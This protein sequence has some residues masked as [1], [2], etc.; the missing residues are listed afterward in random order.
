MA[1]LLHYLP[2]VYITQPQF[3]P[4]PMSILKEDILQANQN[5]IKTANFLTK[6][7]NNPLR[8]KIIGRLLSEGAISVNGLCEKLKTEQSVMSQHLAILREAKLVTTERNGKSVLYSANEQYL[9]EI[10]D[11]FLSITRDF[12]K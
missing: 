4:L 12:G 7:V 2:A 8:Q 1:L 11:S 5:P 3:T 6:A 10:I 9:Q